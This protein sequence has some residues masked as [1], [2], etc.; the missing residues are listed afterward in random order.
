MTLHSNLE[1]WLLAT[2]IPEKLPTSGNNTVFIEAEV[3]IF[4]EKVVGSMQLQI[5]ESIVNMATKAVPWFVWLENNFEI[6]DKY[7][8]GSEKNLVWVH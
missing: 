7:F 4:G 3:G 2:V 8:S 6:K 1:W 5:T